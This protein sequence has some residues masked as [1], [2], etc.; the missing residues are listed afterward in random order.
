MKKMTAFLLVLLLLMGM[1][2]CGKSTDNGNNGNTDEDPAIVEPGDEVADEVVD[3]FINGNTE[4]LAE[5]IKAL[6]GKDILEKS[7]FYKSEFTNQNGL[8]GYTYDWRRISMKDMEMT[9]A[10]DVYH[11]TGEVK[12][13]GSRIRFEA[14]EATFYLMKEDGYWGLYVT[15]KGTSS[16][17]GLPYIITEQFTYWGENEAWNQGLIKLKEETALDRYDGDGTIFIRVKQQFY[18]GV[19]KGFYEK[20]LTSKCA[21][22]SLIIRIDKSGENYEHHVTLSEDLASATL[23]VGGATQFGPTPKAGLLGGT[24]FPKYAAAANS[25]YDQVEEDGMIWF[26]IYENDLGEFQFVGDDRYYTDTFC[27]AKYSADIY[28]S[29]LF[30]PKNYK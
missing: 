8:A 12:G 9:I 19:E 14:E 22:S 30:L 13:G 17:V 21:E 26:L 15:E 16:P 2:A 25:D 23:E 20:V 29:E 6:D 4:D 5:V 18:C 24:V 3:E 10:E 7:D 11:L 28:V 1:T 27:G